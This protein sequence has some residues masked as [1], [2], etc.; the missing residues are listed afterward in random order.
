M[1]SYVNNKTDEIV[2]VVDWQSLAEH[3]AKSLKKGHVWTELRYVPIR[4][5]D[6]RVIVEGELDCHAWGR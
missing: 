3:R 1:F 5:V 2:T 4:M 6:G